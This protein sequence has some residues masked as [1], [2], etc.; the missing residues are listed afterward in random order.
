MK[1]QFNTKEVLTK[2]NDLVKQLAL[3]K[4]LN[5]DISNESDFVEIRFYSAFKN[6]NSVKAELDYFKKNYYTFITDTLKDFKNVFTNYFVCDTGIDDNGCN[7][8]RGIRSSIV[9]A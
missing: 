4:D 1:K 6:L 2:A 8:V 5:V 3:P 9:I 7:N